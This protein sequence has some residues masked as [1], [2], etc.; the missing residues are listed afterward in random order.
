MAIH[1]IQPEFGLPD[2]SQH[3]SSSSV[4]PYPGPKT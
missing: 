2:W 3:R 1:S 4:D